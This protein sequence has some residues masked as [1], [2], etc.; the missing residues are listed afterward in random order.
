MKRKGMIRAIAASFTILFAVSSLPGLTAE[1]GL[2]VTDSSV[3]TKEGQLN[4]SEWYNPNDDLNY[5]D[6]AVVF[7]AEDNKETRLISKFVTVAD[8]YYTDLVEV[9]ATIQ[10]SE[11]PQ[12]ESFI[13]ATGLSGIEAMWGEPG[14]V[15]VHFKNNGGITV[16]VVEY[17]EDG[18]KNVVI[19]ETKCGSLKQA[20]RTNLHI[21]VEGKLKL[22]VNSKTIG[23]VMLSR[24]PTG[25]IGL[26]QTAKCIAQITEFTAKSYK[27]DRPENGNVFEDFE[28]G[29]IN[30][31]CFTSATS[32]SAR[33]LAGLSVEDL[34]GNKVLRFRNVGVGYFGTKQEYS[35][36]ELTFDVPYFARS[37]QYDEYGT[38]VEAPSGEFGV[39]FGDFAADVSGQDYAQS[40]DL[41]LFTGNVQGWFSG[42]KALYT[43]KNLYDENTNDGYSV[44][45]RVID[46]ELTVWMKSLKSD[47]WIELATHTYDNFK[48]GYIKIWSTRDTNLAIDNFKV[49]N[50]DKDPNLTE[51]EFKSAILDQP[52]FEYEPAEMVFREKTEVKEEAGFNW[53]MIVV[54]SSI[55]AV[56][57]IGAGV[58][59]NLITKKK[60]KK[61][62]VKA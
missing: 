62:E 1:A 50:L 14:N 39:S 11:I 28:S 2:S 26:L 29:T 18:D 60:H 17:N 54:Y 22:T 23:T 44:K 48:C 47:N 4:L 31:N 34:D 5:Q 10:F 43:D 12:E 37:Y 27:Y 33:H 55:A 46:G 35:N 21:T 32:S 15:E 19:A 13:V 6:G 57:I 3:A 41:L 20:I 16:E 8:K 61:E 25:Q 59:A 56:V 49:E 38:V 9:N 36:F 7:E 58:A 42:W 45:I 53:M 24:V 40:T 30:D 51:Y 52:D